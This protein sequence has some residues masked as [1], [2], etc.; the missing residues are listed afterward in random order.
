[1]V[2]DEKGFAWLSQPDHVAHFAKDVAPDTARAM[3]AVQQPLAAP[4]FGDIMGVPP[5]RSLPPGTWSPP[6]TRRSHPGC[7][8]V[9]PPAW[10]PPPARSSAA[11]SP[12]VSHPD[13]VMEFIVSALESL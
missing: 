13:E 12:V 8:D 3:W 7:S 6:R 9:S 2:I 5:W 1:M 4:A 11:T 10:T